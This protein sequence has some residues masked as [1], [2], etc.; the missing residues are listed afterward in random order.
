VKNQL[1]IIK[2]KS[3]VLKSLFIKAY[4]GLKSIVGS[5]LKYFYGPLGPYFIPR[6]KRFTL[7]SPFKE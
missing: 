1:I 7:T 6:I 3:L 4:I 2:S 5:I